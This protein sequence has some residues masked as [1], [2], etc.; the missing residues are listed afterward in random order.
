VVAAGG[1]SV[2]VCYTCDTV[3]EEH[4]EFRLTQRR[5]TTWEGVV[6]CKAVRISADDTQG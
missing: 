6:V 1:A 5:T 3:A 4:A 2:R